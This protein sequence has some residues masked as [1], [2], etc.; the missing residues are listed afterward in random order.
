MGYR[1]EIAIAID[2]IVYENAPV[3]VKEAFQ[4]IWDNPDIEEAER[5][6]FHHDFIKWYDSDPVVATINNW[7]G[8]LDE[9]EYGLIE[10]GEDMSDVRM[11]GEYFNYGL[12]FVRKIDF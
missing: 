5:I 4:E 9:T 1:S 3:D 12:D 2:P 10:L 7:L 8:A 11:E 6:V